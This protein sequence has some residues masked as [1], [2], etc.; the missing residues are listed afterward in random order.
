MFSA[1][2][3]PD[4]SKIGFFIKFEYFFHFQKISWNLAKMNFFLFIS[5]FFFW[6]TFFFETTQNRLF[7]SNFNFIF[8]RGRGGD[9]EFPKRGFFRVYIDVMAG[10]NAAENGIKWRFFVMAGVKFS[11]FF[12]ENGT[13]FIPA[14]KKVHFHN[15]VQ[16]KGDWRR[17]NA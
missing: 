12:L 16:L 7:C 8:R 14:P 17:P 15:G 4:P 6:K 10:I 1:C 9:V 3:I 2:R 11:K 5:E 13:F